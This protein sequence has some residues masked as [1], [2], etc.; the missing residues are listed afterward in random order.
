MKEDG[1]TNDGM[2][3]GGA[4]VQTKQDVDGNAQK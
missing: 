4:I 1:T 2:I 3:F